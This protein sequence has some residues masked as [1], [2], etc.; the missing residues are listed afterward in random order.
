MKKAKTMTAAKITDKTAVKI[1]LPVVHNVP[2]QNPESVRNP[3]TSKRAW[4][5][6]GTIML[7]EKS[8]AVAHMQPIRKEYPT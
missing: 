7:P 8:N 1:T 6:I 3:P 2:E 5:I 4:I